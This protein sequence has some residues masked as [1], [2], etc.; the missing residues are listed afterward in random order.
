[1]YCIWH[2]MTSME[3]APA[4]LGLCPTSFETFFFY[5]EATFLQT[6][7]FSLKHLRDNIE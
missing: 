4:V 6:Q 2:T 7:T 1:M 5:P 3:S